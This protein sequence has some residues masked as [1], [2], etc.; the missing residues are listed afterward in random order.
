M[1]LNEFW[2]LLPLWYAL[3]LLCTQVDYE[4]GPTEGGYNMRNLL[5]RQDK[6]G[7]YIWLD[8][9]AFDFDENSTNIWI[10][11]PDYESCHTMKLDGLIERR[12][13]V[14]VIPWLFSPV[15]EY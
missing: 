6:K 13:A 2:T 7:T 5:R 14:R 11:S 15:I 10:S 1:N 3:L 4:Q 12:I 9:S 8:I